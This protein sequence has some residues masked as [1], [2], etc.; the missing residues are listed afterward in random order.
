[1]PLKQDGRG[2]RGVPP[3]RCSLNNSIVTQK[4][5]STAGQGRVA[6]QLQHIYS[7]PL[8][9]PPLP[10]ACSPALSP[11][12][13]SPRCLHALQ[14]ISFKEP[15]SFPAALS[16]FGDVS[17]LRAHRCSRFW[18][19]TW[20]RWEVD[21]RCGQYHPL[22]FKMDRRRGIWPSCC[23]CMLFTQLF[24]EDIWAPRGLEERLKSEVSPAVAFPLPASFPAGQSSAAS[25]KHANLPLKEEKI[26][27]QQARTLPYSCPFTAE[28]SS[29]MLC[30]SLSSSC[31][32]WSHFRSIT[33]GITAHWAFLLL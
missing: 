11:Q 8:L 31:P 6:P 23:C 1:M 29:E 17:S 13:P 27:L 4:L 24:S 28:I 20:Y 30:I 7:T 14:L 3:P 9:P 32:T 10:T 16:F 15:A 21:S 25:T 5:Q 18:F 2:W 26:N 19:G 33:S 12:R 22:C